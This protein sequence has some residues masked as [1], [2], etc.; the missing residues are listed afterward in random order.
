MYCLLGEPEMNEAM[1]MLE[2]LADKHGLLL[3]AELIKFADDVWAQATQAEQQA[4]AMAE[5]S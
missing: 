1:D 2:A 3:T 4:N 5:V